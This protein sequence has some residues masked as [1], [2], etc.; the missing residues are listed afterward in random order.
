MAK[1]KGK[2]NKSKN[3]DDEDF[4][5]SGATFT[6]DFTDEEEG[7]GGGFRVKE[8]IHSFTVKKL[9]PDT[10]KQGNNMLVAY[11]EHDDTGKEKRAYLPFTPKALWK[12]RHFLQSAGVEVPQGKKFKFP[13]ADVIGAT[14]WGVVE[15][16]EPN[17][18]GNVYSDITDFVEEPK[19]DKGKKKSKKDKGKKKMNIDEEL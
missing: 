5:G 4:L 16:G 12:A 6:I 17:E 19:K 15:D 1:N 2:K 18:K 11:L 8:G 13:V 14:V 3:E 7:G 10:S 9:K